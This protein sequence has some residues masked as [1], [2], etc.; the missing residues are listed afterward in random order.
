MFTRANQRYFIGFALD[1]SDIG[2][3][4]T[5]IPSKTELTMPHRGGVHA[6]V[7]IMTGKLY[8]H[9]TVFY[10]SFTAIVLQSL[11]IL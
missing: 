4:G 1:T 8:N 3:D 7:I 10:V 5:L 6:S 11:I 2:G 9:R